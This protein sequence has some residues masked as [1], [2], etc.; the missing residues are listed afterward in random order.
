MDIRSTEFHGAQAVNLVLI[1]AVEMRN[2]LPNMQ[3][4]SMAYIWLRS[5]GMI[6]P[7]VADQVLIR[8]DTHSHNQGFAI[9]SS[10][11]NLM[12]LN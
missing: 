3:F 4:M 5:S 11:M 6:V 9:N 12:C 7:Q 2:N 10:G 1:G 8:A